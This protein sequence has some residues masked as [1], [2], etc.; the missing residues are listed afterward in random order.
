MGCPADNDVSDVDTSDLGIPL[1]VLDLLLRTIRSREAG[2]VHEQCAS[3]GGVQGHV[4]GHARAPR[5]EQL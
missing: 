5:V 2:F 4:R 1:M 3:D